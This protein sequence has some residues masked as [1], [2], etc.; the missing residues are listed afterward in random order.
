MPL[1]EYRCKDCDRVFEK[2]VPLSSAAASQECPECGGEDARRLLS[3]F[4]SQSSG[5]MMTGGSSGG[6]GSGCGCH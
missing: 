4:A 1:Y 5:G 6:C 3:M 2:L